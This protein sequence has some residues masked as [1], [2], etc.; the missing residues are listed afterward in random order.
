[1]ARSE[2]VPSKDQRRLLLRDAWIGDAV[3]CLYTRELILRSTGAVDGA[4][5]ARLTS[6]Q[7]LSRLG[8][9]SEVEARIGR[10]YES[11]G[12]QGA[13]TWM[14]EHLLPHYQRQG[15]VVN[16]AADGAENR[17]K[18]ADGAG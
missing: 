11:G 9:P 12:L 10:A 5:Y 14:N 3:L 18:P 7:F 6:N 4:T 1:M 8:E 17:D 15:L 2:A 16:S 13:F